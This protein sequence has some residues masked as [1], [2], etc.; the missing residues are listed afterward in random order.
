VVLYNF[1]LNT[2]CYPLEH[3][4]GGAALRPPARATFEY[5][6]ASHGPQRHFPAFSRGNF[7]FIWKIPNEREC[8]A[9][10]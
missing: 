1:Y 5:G 3:A 4:L 9:R 7:Y 10:K 2:A 6:A 8:P